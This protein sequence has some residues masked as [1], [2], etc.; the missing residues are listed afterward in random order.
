MSL[1][2]LPDEVIEQLLENLTRDE[3][4]RFQDVLK[5]ALHE[6]STAAQAIDAG[7]YH[8][9]GRTSSHSDR[10]GATTLFM[11]STSPVGHGVKGQ[12]G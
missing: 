11:P 6:Y 8:Q 12:S 4:E 1:T 7:L 5:S 9:P 2:V 3:A 10:T